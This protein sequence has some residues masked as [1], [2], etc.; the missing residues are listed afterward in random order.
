MML[1]T[2][3]TDEQKALLP[4]DDD[5]RFYQEHGWYHSKTLFTQD[6]MDAVLR[7]SER[8]YA[9]DVDEPTEIL[10]RVPALNRF[11]P[12]GEYRGLRKND[13]SSMY[14]KGLRALVTHP[15]LGAVAARL[16]ETPEVRLWHDQLLYKPTQDPERAANVGWHTDKGYWKTCSSSNLLT[17]WIPF[18]DCDDVMGTIT[19]I[20][21][22]HKWPDNTHNLNFFSNDLDGLEAK[23]DTGGAS[24][25]K[26]PMNLK[27]GQVSFHH[28]LTIHGSG[29]NH[30]PNPR[31][32]IAV[33]MQDASNHWMEYHF[34]DG[35][36]A[37]HDNDRLCRC[38]SS[39]VPDYADPDFCPALYKAGTL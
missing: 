15:L 39:G 16:A 4:S 10:E 12:K 8:Y 31:R 17:A 30:S 3:L 22:S 32:S 2:Q 5:V 37:D 26:I 9:V 14:S 20:D 19:M 24:V 27:R 35:R 28:C 23:F 36:L 33:H 38:T 6:E 29:P 34:P 21:G 7:A 13:F 11:R 25:V 1:T 18:T